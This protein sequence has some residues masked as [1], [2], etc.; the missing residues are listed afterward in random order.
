MYW[1]FLIIFIH[2]K[3]PDTSALIQQYIL[4]HPNATIPRDLLLGELSD[5]PLAVIMT[6]T[7][8]R[9]LHPSLVRVTR[10]R[11]GSDGMTVVA[12]SRTA[13]RRAVRRHGV[14]ILVQ[15]LGPYRCLTYD[16][17]IETNWILSYFISKSLCH[18]FI[19]F[20]FDIIYVLLA[21]YLALL[22]SWFYL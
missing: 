15:W 18:Y 12:C 8:G 1:D 7:T 20:Y 9:T 22:Y 2:P 21:Y 3:N 4:I 19:L 17:K 16:I 5:L 6:A 11:C 10:S 14:T 13:G